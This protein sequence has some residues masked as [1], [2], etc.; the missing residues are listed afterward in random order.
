MSLK[1]T[2]LYTGLV[3]I[4]GLSTVAIAP[5]ADAA[6]VRSR[7][8]GSVNT[9]DVNKVNDFTE[10]YEKF[11]GDIAGATPNEVPNVASFETLKTSNDALQE[12]DFKDLGETYNKVTSDIKTR[13]AAIVEK[14]DTINS[15]P[16]TN[17][18]QAVRDLNSEMQSYNELL[19][20]M[21][22]AATDYAKN[23]NNS[24]NQIFGYIMA[25]VGVLVVGAIVWAVI[26]GRKKSHKAQAALFGND[27]TAASIAPKDQKM[28]AEVY[29]RLLKYEEKYKKA[30][31]VGMDV[32]RQLGYT[33]YETT[34]AQESLGKYRS[35]IFEFAALIALSNNN[36]DH[37]KAML[38]R[39]EEYLGSRDF[40]TETARSI[41]K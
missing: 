32:E 10:A 11:A 29:A 12:H 4:I 7:G 41:Q 8:N 1:K 14:S 3:A 34:A 39:A 35:L 27:P 16:L 38:G 5:D 36:S 19:D 37:A 23:R 21:S 6:R 13:A 26:A 40:Y 17:V 20:D 33:P 22:S 24:S 15:T 31:K 9:T 30:D 18:S 28:L 25:G 2:L